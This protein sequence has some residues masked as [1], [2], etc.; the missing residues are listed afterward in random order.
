MR[1]SKKKAR[2]QA[3][4]AASGLSGRE[5]RL[6]KVERAEQAA[7][8]RLADATEQ[9]KSPFQGYTQ[10]QEN[11]A[12]EAELADLWTIVLNHQEKERLAHNDCYQSWRTTS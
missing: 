5:E 11:G 6:Q 9:A 8:S 7:T 2:K 1:K 10:L 4:K 12:S 3:K